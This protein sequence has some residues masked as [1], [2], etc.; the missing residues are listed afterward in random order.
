MPSSGGGSSFYVN[1]YWNHMHFFKNQN[2]PSQHYSEYKTQ[3]SSL[4]LDS[5]GTGNSFRDFN[6]A[7]LFWTN[8]GEV[9]STQRYYL[10][11]RQYSSFSNPFIYYSAY[12]PK[13]SQSIC[14]DTNNYYICRT[15]SQFNQRRYYIVA[16]P[17]GSVSTN[18]FDYTGTFPQSKDVTSSFYSGYCGWT[19]GGTGNYYA[20]YTWTANSGYLS[21]ATPTYGV[22]V[23]IYGSTLV[24]YSSPF[25]IAINLNGHA[26]YSNQRTTGQNTGSFIQITASSFST[27]Y[28][29]GAY[30]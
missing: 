17:K 22:A 1:F 21:E 2:I 25:V 27:L 19:R 29:C 11:L 6:E 14:S 7:N 16:Q 4:T 23:P 20:E 10:Y 18:T 9:L 15:Y 26:L 5:T 28:G 8:Y 12:Y 24:S 13:P 3:S 30:L